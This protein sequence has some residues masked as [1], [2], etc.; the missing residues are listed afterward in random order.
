MVVNGLRMDDVQS[1]HHDMDLAVPMDAVD[2]IE[3]YA[4]LDQLSTDPMPWL[5]R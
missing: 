4:V 2:R 1:G 3:G 5:G